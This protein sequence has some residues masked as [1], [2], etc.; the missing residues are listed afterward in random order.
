MAF[1]VA[2]GDAYASTELT[3]G[4][5]DRDSQH[6]GPPCAL[7]GRALDRAGGL[8]AARVARVTFEILGP[9]PIGVL[10]CSASVVRP[11]RSVELIEGAL[12]HEGRDLIR[13][14]AWRI[15]TAPVTLDPAPTPQAPPPGPQEGE[16][17]GYFPVE[18]DAG[19]HTAMDVRFLSGGYLEAGPARVWMRM[20][21]ALVE[22]EEPSP[23]DR[24]LV[25]ADAGNGVSGPLDFRRYVFINADLSV[26]VSRLPAG[27]WVF[28][29]AVTYAEP[30][31]VGLSDSALFDGAGP[32]GRASQS[33]LVAE[34]EGGD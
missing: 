24:L 3:R 27:E 33:L 4:P 16:A 15:R 9:V 8:A 5:W 34:R 30:D 14:R 7:L 20:R 2:Q 13:A 12:S 17:R 10:A 1:Y 23:L 26:A 11:G 18:W 29:D 6:A 22:G 32:I 31:G 21:G 19:F 25:A 28:L